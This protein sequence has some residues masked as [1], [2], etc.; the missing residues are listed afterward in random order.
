MLFSCAE[1][2]SAV[3]DDVLQVSVLQIAVHQRHALH[4]VFPQLLS[5]SGVSEHLFDKVR[6][7]KHLYVGTYVEH[8]YLSP[9][10]SEME[11]EH[12]CLVEK[13]RIPW[14]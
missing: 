8:M 7:I 13:G 11:K 9:A 12:I 3:Q 4:R 14:R 6:C 10:I 5:N 1:C 2:Y